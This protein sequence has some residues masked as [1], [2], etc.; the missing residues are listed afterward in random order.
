VEQPHEVL[1]GAISVVRD[2]F[3]AVAG[4]S[5]RTIL[6]STVLLASAVSAVTGF[7][8]TQYYSIDVLSSLVFVPEDCAFDWAT[9]FG[10]H[11]F[12][13]A[14]LPLDF[15]MRP[16]PWEPYPAP[17][18]STHLPHLNSYAPALMLNNYPAPGMLPHMTFGL[19]GHWLHAPRLGLFGYLTFLTIAVVTPA[20]W[21]A[22][23]AR[24]L[25]RVVVFVAFTIMAIPAWMV[26]DRGNSSGFLVPIALV[27]L[28]A[29]RRWRWGLVTVMVVLAALVKPQFVVL[30]VA[31]F[32]ARKWRWGGI[33]VAGVVVSYVAAYLLWPRDFPA[34]IA[35]SIH[36][37]L[38]YTQ[39]FRA[40]TT[41]NASFGE[42]LLTIPDGIKASQNGGTVPEGFL[43][44]PR[45]MIGYVVLL[46]V[47]VA[48]LALGRRIPPIMVGIVLLATAALFP[49]LSLPYYLVFALPVAA[50]VARDPDGP[51]GTG[52][53]DRFA[54]LGDR[55]RAV[56]ICVSVA[57]AL[58]IAFI[59]LPGPPV[60][61][62]I[63]GQ[64]Q[65]G[66]SGIVQTRA[67]V[68]TTM[69]VS[70]LLWLLACGAIIVSYARRP[71]DSRSDD[72]RL[73]SEDPPNTASSTSS[74]SEELGELSPQRPA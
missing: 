51:P 62:E 58:S 70:P 64:T 35:Q 10:R 40:L 71:A 26:I 48:V 12:S 21:A 42:G 46:L 31:L 41:L 67:L 2:R 8:L 63:V 72:Q 50:L 36:N 20:V 49:A 7:V 4:Q 38:A 24:G 25:E 14:I 17:A 59:A 16:D 3:G 47:V 27:F 53:F 45:S 22:R 33:A 69:V 55:R 34:T 52:I 54:T 74:K 60:H 29:L 66:V 57:A 18:L 44:G 65:I 43:A 73:A 23:G 56:G 13:D 32:A 28:V 30:G 61:E 5:E 39:G 68:T 1:R 6:L 37:T 9:N 15:G 11:C 19:L